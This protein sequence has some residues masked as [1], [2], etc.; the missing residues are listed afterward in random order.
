MDGILEVI[1]TVFFEIFSERL[2]VYSFW[3]PHVQPTEKKRKAIKILSD[4]IL[5][6]DIAA[7]LVGIFL[8]SIGIT[9]VGV[10]LLAVGLLYIVIMLI[11][12]GGRKH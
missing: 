8:L 1:F 2:S 3:S 4:I 9:V 11:L 5:I 6:T 7:M 10:S 12:T